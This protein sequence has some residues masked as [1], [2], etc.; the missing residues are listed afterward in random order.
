MT[1]NPGIFNILGSP[2]QTSGLSGPVQ[3]LQPY[4]E[5][6]SL[7]DSLGLA[8]FMSLKQVLLK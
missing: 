6:A 8:V 7:Y 4:H 3:E 5:V 1:H 2:M